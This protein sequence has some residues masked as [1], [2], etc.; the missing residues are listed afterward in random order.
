MDQKLLETYRL[1][2]VEYG[3]DLGLISLITGDLLAVAIDS[4]N[5][6]VPGII[7]RFTVSDKWMT[8]NFGEEHN[9]SD[10]I[11]FLQ[12]RYMWASKSIE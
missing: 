4:Q 1:I 6:S 10:V 8:D 5:L 9:W 2:K 12:Q 3:N 11:K 7:P